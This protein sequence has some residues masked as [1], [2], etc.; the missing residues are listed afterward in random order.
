MFEC[1]LW[2]MASD[3]KEHHW[4]PSDEDPAE[5]GMF[6]R[7]RG[8]IEEAC[9]ASGVPFELLQIRHTWG[10]AAV[11]AGYGGN[12]GAPERQ[13]KFLEEVAQRAPSTYGVIYMMDSERDDARGEFMVLKLANQKISESYELLVPQSS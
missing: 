11:S 7:V 6:E 13:R 5:D 3:L 4:A 9:K 10:G 8:K 2:L 12:H 1:F